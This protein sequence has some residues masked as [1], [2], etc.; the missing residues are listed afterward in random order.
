MLSFK[1]YHIRESL[2]IAYDDYFAESFSLR[3]TKG[4]EK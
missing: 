1:E 4:N 3:E 2:L